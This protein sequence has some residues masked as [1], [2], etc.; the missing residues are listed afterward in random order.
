MECDTFLEKCSPCDL[1]SARCTFLGV[2]SNAEK[3]SERVLD[4]AIKLV[5]EASVD[6][7]ECPNEVLT[8]V[9]ELLNAFSA[10]RYVKQLAYYYDLCREFLASHFVTS[11]VQ[12]SEFH[13]AMCKNMFERCQSLHKIMPLVGTYV[14]CSYEPIR[15]LAIKKCRDVPE[16]VELLRDAGVLRANEEDAEQLEADS[17]EDTL[18]IDK[19]IEEVVDMKPTIFEVS[20]NTPTG[21]HKDNDVS[22]CIVVSTDRSPARGGRRKRSRE[23]EDRE[24]I[25]SPTKRRK[26]VDSDEDEIQSNP[27]GSMTRYSERV[28]G[29]C[30][31]RVRGS[32]DGRE[33]SGR[34]GKRRRA[35]AVAEFMRDLKQVESHS[36]DVVENMARTEMAEYQALLMK[37]LAATHEAA[38]K[39]N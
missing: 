27:S 16:C 31:V 37:M 3:L 33:Q 21:M 6:T 26:S 14:N 30:E 19:S 22:E 18:V 8:R 15:A 28:N 11:D 34:S 9:L 35:A 2:L 20:T 39:L 38:C 7:A 13:V 1:A 25:S 23:S 5:F 4:K 10:E 29:L 12:V 32:R 36:A 17:L 24:L